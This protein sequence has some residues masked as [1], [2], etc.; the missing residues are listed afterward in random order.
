MYDKIGK[1]K[2]LRKLPGIHCNLRITCVMFCLSDQREL[3][4]SPCEYSFYDSWLQNNTQANYFTIF[5]SLPMMTFGLNR[6]QENTQSRTA[7]I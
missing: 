4:D 7:F 2:P 3:G 6:K 1:N 5:I